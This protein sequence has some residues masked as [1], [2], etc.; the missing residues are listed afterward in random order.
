MAGAASSP[1]GE[2]QPGSSGEWARWAASPV[3]PP[4]PPRPPLFRTPP[5]LTP[6]T[7]G[8]GLVLGDALVL[9]IA[10]LF[11]GSIEDEDGWNAL[12]G[13]VFVVGGL[14]L[15]GLGALGLR[16]PRLAGW[17]LIACGLPACV[18]T[19][20][21]MASASDP[22]ASL[23]AWLFLVPVLGAPPLGGF[24]LVAGRD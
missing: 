17:I 12:V 21:G 9:L 2:G 23:W 6:Q 22:E 1:G 14:L 16:Y 13:E 20:L 10:G 3:P 5:W 15:A 19:V 18:V 7:V 4:Q 11:T 24:F 8:E